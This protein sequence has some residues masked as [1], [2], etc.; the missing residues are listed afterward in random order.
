MQ[1]VSRF[2]D[3]IS[4]AREHILDFAVLMIIL[5]VG[6]VYTFEIESVLDIALYDETSYLY[7]GLLIPNGFPSAEAAPLYALWYY[8]LSLL[9]HD[10]IDLYF[11]NYKLMT[12]LP[13][14]YALYHSPRLECVSCSLPFPF[15]RLSVQL[16]K[17]PHL[18]EGKSLRDV[19][20]AIGL[21]LVKFRSESDIAN[22]CSCHHYIP[23]VLCS[24]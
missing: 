12:V 9:Q 24:S 14:A 20:V 4:P 17:F 16:R 22:S 19:G 3:A 21:L 2:P 8:L 10:A 5:L 23:H 15:I 18:A 1:P 13:P 7:R 11:L 6:W